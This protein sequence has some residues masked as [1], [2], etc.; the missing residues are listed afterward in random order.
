MYDIKPLEE[1]WEQYNRKRKR[2][3]FVIF[4][5]LFLILALAVLFFQNKTL[6]LSKI[7][8]ISKPSSIKSSSGSFFEK[9]LDTLALKEDSSSVEAVK[10]VV[11]DNPMNPED[12][13]VDADD[14][15]RRSPSVVVQARKQAK[16]KPKKKLHFE[17]IDA[18]S[19]EAYAEVK[20]RFEMA[21]DPDD[22]LFLAR[23]YYHD[24]N[25]RKAAYWALQ[26]NK[27]NGD[28]EESWLIFARSKAK[29]G[30][31]NEAIRVLTQYVEKSHSIEAKKLL[32]KLKN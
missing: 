20:N 7:D 16:V 23:N 21:P 1:Q 32:K 9:P 18:N 3:L 2:P 15:Q 5:L 22:S 8:H 29:T 26:T 12:V 19:A 31:K 27:L 28:I 14:G 17:M 4:F 13:F 30:H 10:A 11:D 6:I 25:Y 24:G